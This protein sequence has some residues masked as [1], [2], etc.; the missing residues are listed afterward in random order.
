MN[1]V[2]AKNG[3]TKYIMLRTTTIVNTIK[4]QMCGTAAEFLITDLQRP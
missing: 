2:G 1:V 4:M 3:Y